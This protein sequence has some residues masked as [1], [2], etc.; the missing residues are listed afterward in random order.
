MQAL[1]ERAWGTK[2]DGLEQE[3]DEKKD[4]MLELSSSC[5]GILHCP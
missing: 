4:T 3:K 2:K 1:T 5:V